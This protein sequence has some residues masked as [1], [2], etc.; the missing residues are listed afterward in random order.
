[1]QDLYHQPYHRPRS[2]SSNNKALKILEDNWRLASATGC[3]DA[4]ELSV[5]GAFE[6]V[7]VS[8]SSIQQSL[9]RVHYSTTF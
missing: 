5:T 8:Y 2:S 9:Y 6:T 4:A 7:T 3:L 1:M